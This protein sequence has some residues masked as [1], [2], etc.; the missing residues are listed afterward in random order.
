MKKWAKS[1][2]KKLFLKAVLESA[3]SEFLN[4]EQGITYVLIE[5][6]GDQKFDIHHP[7][8]KD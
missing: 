5:F 6:D 8:Q 7:R 3:K 1:T 2:I 4:C